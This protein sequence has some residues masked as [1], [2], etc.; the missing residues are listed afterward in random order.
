MIQAGTIK[1][2]GRLNLFSEKFCKRK[3]RLRF[4]YRCIRRFMRDKM[5]GGILE[6]WG[7]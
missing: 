6:A 4:Q 2:S 7:E 1:E 5:T 3:D